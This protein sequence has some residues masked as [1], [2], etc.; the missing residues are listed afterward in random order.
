M[1][2][3]FGV[4]VVIVAM[5][6]AC[7]AVTGAWERWLTD[8]VTV[9]SRQEQMWQSHDAYLAWQPKRD[10]LLGGAV[11]AA[12][13]AWLIILALAGAF[14]G[15]WAVR[16]WDGRVKNRYVYAAD[17]RGLYPVTPSALDSAASM[18]AAGFHAARIEAARHPAIPASVTH[19]SFKEG[20]GALPR[21]SDATPGALPAPAELAA[22]PPFAQLLAQRTAGPGFI[23]VGATPEG[24]VSY[25]SLKDLMSTAVVGVPGSGKTSTALLLLSQAAVYCGARL[26]VI[27]PHA[28]NAQSLL[29]GVSSLASV[30]W[31]DPARTPAD[32]AALVEALMD[33][34]YRR[35]A[36]KQGPHIILAV[37]EFT[38][39]MRGEQG[40]RIAYG[41]EEIVQEGR[42]YDV[43]AALLGQSYIAA[44]SG[45]T[46]LRDALG[47]ALIHKSKPAQA[48]TVWP[49]IGNET[50][51]LAPGQALFARATDAEPRRILVPLCTPGDVATLARRLPAP[52]EPYPT[53]RDDSASWS[54]PQSAPPAQEPLPPV[55]EGRGWD[56]D[57][58]DAPDNLIAFPG[59]KASAEAAVSAVSP[60]SA[61]TTAESLENEAKIAVPEALTPLTGL[62][63]REQQIVALL[64]QRKTPHEI[65]VET[66]GHKGGPTYQARV[67][68]VK[69]LLTRLLP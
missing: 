43:T 3:L 27:D 52:H 69:D 67:R 59:R 38:A 10:A 44:R 63:E 29:T 42:K 57:E 11:T 54:A 37:D 53:R 16:A 31:R 32:A 58:G 46:P 45:G 13:T 50:L 66:T 65:A 6:I 34:L 40:S 68:E 49:G 9:A 20:N 14:G 19:Y 4:I 55:V 30:F 7:S 62:T 17:K 48:R 18:S 22:C 47:S 33:E 26:A 39:L 41:I 56:A 36:G 21:P 64:K 24:G 51:A 35:K 23:L 2:W 12:N 61:D 5:M 60:I 15:I 8:P 28:G 25:A 1:R